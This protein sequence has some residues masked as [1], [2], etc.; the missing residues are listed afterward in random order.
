MATTTTIVPS[1]LATL[2]P[3]AHPTRGQV[4][5]ALTIAATREGSGGFAAVMLHRVANGQDL[6]PSQW[7]LGRVVALTRRLRG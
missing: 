5:E 6:T 1:S 4:I 7:I 3:A 2:T